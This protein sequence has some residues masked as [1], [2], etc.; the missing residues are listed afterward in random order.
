MCGF[1]GY[2][3]GTAF[4]RGTPE[5]VPLGNMTR[6]IEHRGPD[7]AGH[8]V[9]AVNGI[10]LGFRRLA[11]VDLSAA[12]HQPMQ[13]HNGRWVLVYNGEIYNH[14]VLRAQLE[15]SGHAPR[16]RGHSDTETLL[17]A[18]AVWGVEATLAR[19][20]GMFA[21]ALWDRETLSLTLA[22]DRMG[23][24]PLYY[25]WQGRGR[26]ASFSFGSELK[27]L[28][29]HP[30]FEG[31]V[32]RDALCLLLRHNYIAAPRSIYCGINKLEP[33]CIL[34]VSLAQ[35]EPKVMRYWSMQQ[36]IEQ[37]VAKPFDGSPMQAVDA[38]EVLLKD[39]VAQ[40]IVADVPLGAFLSGGV[41]SS[42][43]VALMQ[44]QS[45]NRV[46]TFTIGFHDAA[47]NEAPHAKAVAGHLGTDHHELYVNAQQ[48]LDVIDRLPGLYCEP[49]ADESQI[50]TLLVSQLARQQVTV[51]LSGDAGD[52]LFC[53]YS[54]YPHAQR[55]WNTLS[56]VPV[57][58]RHAAA[59]ASTAISPMYWNAALAP[60][61]AFRSP[62]KRTR[63]WGDTVHK[64]AGLLLAK[65]AAEFYCKLNS[66]WPDPASVVMD[67][68]EYRE[69]I[70]SLPPGLQGLSFTEHMMAWDAVGYLPNDILAKIDRAAMG[71]SLEG[72]VPFLDHRV[73]EFAWQLPLSLKL[74]AG[75][76]KWVLRQVLYRHV[77]RALIDRPKMG[78][79]VPIGDWLRGPLRDW[80]EDLL[81]ETRLRREGFFDAPTIRRTWQEHQNG[82]R[83]WQNKLWGVLMFQAWLQSTRDATPGGLR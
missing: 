34:T 70:N 72:R 71:V 39:A 8:W 59:R 63:N 47:Y 55:I 19:C 9:D 54:R 81:G 2:L 17:A 75:V 67:N 21:F 53:G 1:A 38:L 20:I 25:G 58:L 61:T 4:S 31:R 18:I 80:A 42:T 3:G 5:G 68:A 41:D 22:R 78:F 49:F 65:D 11:I 14:L 23:E 51:S 52:E 27:A 16:W 83:N 43:V 7:D 33:G 46:K 24:K 40:Q 64:A 32:D 37:G 57:G 10:A 36:T 13:A 29:A 26:D 79:G 77:P 56:K 35:P 82:T 48:A 62:H 66:Y 60:M 15:K 69:S 74:R 44:A 50:P 28:R 30:A 6:A 45:S 73:V 12:G 76:G